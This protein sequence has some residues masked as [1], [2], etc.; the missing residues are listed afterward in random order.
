M[1]KLISALVVASLAACGVDSAV[2]DDGLLSA[3]PVASEAAQALTADAFP[4]KAGNSWSLADGAGVTKIVRVVRS[5]GNV[6]FV[7]GIAQNG[8]VWMAFAGQRLYV[9]NVE[10]KA[11]QTF[12]NF[13]SNADQKFAVGGVCEQFT[14]RRVATSATVKTP[15]GT[16]ARVTKFEFVLSPPPYV[17]C[18]A[19][20]FSAMSFAQ[21]VGLLEIGTP[22][23]TTFALTSATVNGKSFPQAGV[24]ATLT[25]APVVQLDNE[26]AAQP[27]VALALRNDSNR[28][29]TYTFTSG[30]QFELEITTATGRSVYFWSADKSFIQGTTTMTIA[31]GQTKT[32]NESLNIQFASAG[33]HVVRAWLPTADGKGPEATTKVEFKGGVAPPCF[34]GGCSGTVCSDNEGVIS[35]CEFRPQYACYAS[36]SCERQTSGQCGWTMTP[37]LQ[38]CLARP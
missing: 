28:A 15:A 26:G 2:V 6:H 20:A 29:V 17:R 30:Q 3:G 5:S 27:R 22:A 9:W 34:I 11:W 24:T 35:T 8:G 18:A 36:A 31:A 13:G 12:A 23:L 32:I 14:S 25:M 4:L 7:E 37:A 33:W 10:A 1:N 21:D 38:A 16:F 19:P